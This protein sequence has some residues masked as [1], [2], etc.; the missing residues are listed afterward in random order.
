MSP[1][2]LVGLSVIILVGMWCER[3]LLVAPSIWKGEE[4]PLGLIELSITAGFVG[5]IGLTAMV[6]LMKVPFLPV[7]DPLFQ[8]ETVKLVDE[9]KKEEGAA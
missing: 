9:L 2:W 4:M 5:M 7:S 1:R 6:F 3:F 8:E